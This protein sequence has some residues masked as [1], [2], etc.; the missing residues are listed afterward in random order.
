MS[1]PEG[2][3][4][5]FGTEESAFVPDG[6]DRAEEAALREDELSEE[7][8]IAGQDASAVATDPD[9]G[10]ESAPSDISSA[11]TGYGTV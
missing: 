9:L 1:N 10:L 4:N 8:R 7:A 11:D 6:E 2:L 5:S 3:I